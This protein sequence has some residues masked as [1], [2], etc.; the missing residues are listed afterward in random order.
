MSAVVD[1]APRKGLGKTSMVFAAGTALLHV[2]YAMIE[3]TV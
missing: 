2:A 1:P 3:A